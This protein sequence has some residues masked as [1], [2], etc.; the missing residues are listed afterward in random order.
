MLV[1][2]WVK[3]ASVPV[4]F[5]IVFALYL[6]IVLENLEGKYLQ[7]NSPQKSEEIA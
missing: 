5:L 3:L 1:L 6:H 4:L 7:V 2:Y